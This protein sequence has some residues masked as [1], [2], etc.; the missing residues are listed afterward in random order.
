[1][2]Y[3]VGQLLPAFVLFVA[4]VAELADEVEK[5]ESRLNALDDVVKSFTAFALGL[6]EEEQS[7]FS[8]HPWSQPSLIQH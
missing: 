1:M 2:R 4:S 7:A 5:D 6:P 8:V 3:A